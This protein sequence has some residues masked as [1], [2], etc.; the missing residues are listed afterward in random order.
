MK[1]PAKA[2]ISTAATPAVSAARKVR[3]AAAMTATLPASRRPGTFPSRENGHPFHVMKKST[4]HIPAMTK[5]EPSFGGARKPLRGD[6]VEP[7]GG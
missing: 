7:G 1:A 2:I 5:S 3:I 4:C 6:R